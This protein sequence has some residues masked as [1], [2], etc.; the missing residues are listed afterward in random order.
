MATPTPPSKAARSGCSHIHWWLKQG[1][2]IG[3][4][5]LRNMKPGPDQEPVEVVVPA[6][7]IIT[8]EVWMPHRRPTGE[9]GRASMTGH[10]PSVKNWKFYALSANGKKDACR[11]FHLHSDSEEVPV[12]NQTRRS[13]VGAPSAATCASTV[14]AMSVCVVAILSVMVSAMAHQGWRPGDSGC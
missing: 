1:A 10:A 2:Y 12:Y 11:I 5:F 3:E 7:A 13:A 8:K 6:P 14:R 4:G 9:P